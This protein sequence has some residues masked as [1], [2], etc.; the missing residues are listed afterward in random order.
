MRT[1]SD[2][3]V[4]VNVTSLLSENW[5][6][7]NEA[8]ERGMRKLGED[9][10]MCICWDTE[11]AEISLTTTTQAVLLKRLCEKGE[12]EVVQK[13]KKA[14]GGQTRREGLSLYIQIHPGSGLGTT[15]YC[16]VRRNAFSKVHG[17]N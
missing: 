1:L 9:I 2:D 11:S 8:Y 16:E 14:Q 17:D 6:I 10:V 13:I 3:E 12:I 4:R 5:G 15:I 7:I